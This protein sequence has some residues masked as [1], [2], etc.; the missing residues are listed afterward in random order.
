MI[1]GSSTPH[2]TF[3]LSLSN[4]EKKSSTLTPETCNNSTLVPDDLVCWTVNMFRCA[5]LW[6]DRS[7]FII[8]SSIQLVISKSVAF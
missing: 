2:C 8:S 1:S 6:S 7:V 3:H 4:S 5:F